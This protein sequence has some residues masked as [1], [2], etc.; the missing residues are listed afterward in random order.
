MEKVLNDGLATISAPIINY[1]QFPIFIRLVED[2]LDLSEM[3]G[4]SDKEAAVYD[5]QLRLWGVQA[6]DAG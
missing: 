2:T 5:R 6:W 1:D 3:A 4:I